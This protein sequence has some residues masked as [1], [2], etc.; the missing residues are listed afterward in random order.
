MTLVDDPI[1][2]QPGVQVRLD[3]YSLPMQESMTQECDWHLPCAGMFFFRSQA[4]QLLFV[5][6]YQHS[7]S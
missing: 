7:N 3:D 6:K 4:D 5:L 2:G 1:S